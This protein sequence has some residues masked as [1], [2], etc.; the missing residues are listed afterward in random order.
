MRNP[1]KRN[2]SRS[3]IQALYSFTPFK[4]TRTEPYTLLLAP[5]GYLD[6][7]PSVIDYRS[8][9]CKDEFT[10]PKPGWDKPVKQPYSLYPKT[11]SE[12]TSENYVYSLK[13]A[14]NEN[15]WRYPPAYMEFNYKVMKN[16]Y[17][18]QLGW[19]VSSSKKSCPMAKTCPDRKGSECKFYRGPQP[20][21]RLYK[22][23]PEIKSRFTDPPYAAGLE[24]FA[25][26]RYKDSPLMSLSFTEDGEFKALI[27]SVT[28]SPQIP[29]MF[30][31]PSV[32]TQEGIGL[33][34]KN[35]N[36]IELKFKKDVLKDFILDCLEEDKV[37]ANWI[38]VKYYLYQ[39]PD[40]NE[41][42]EIREKRGIPAFNFIEEVVSDEIS[43]TAQ[44]D[45]S[46]FYS[47]VKETDFSKEEAALDFANFVFLHSLA[48]ILRDRLVAE[49]G[50]SEENINYYIDH[51]RLHSIGSWSGKTRIVIFETAIGGFGYLKDLKR[52]IEE[53]GERILYN[54]LEKFIN[55][56]K[57]HKEKTS[58]KYSYLPDNL[59]KFK[60]RYG[61]LVNIV[62]RSYKS[63]FPKI[64]LYPHPNSI[65][66][67]LIDRIGS[68]DDEA[69]GILDDIFQVAPTCWDGCQVC[70]IDET[71]CN[72]LPYDQPY[73]VSSRLLSKG[74]QE[75]LS[76]INSPVISKDLQEGAKEE[77]LS[78]I[79][80]ASNTIDLITP[81]IS[82][83]I[84][85][86][87][88]D[89]YNQ[90]NIRIRI[91]T[92]EDLENDTQIKSIEKLSEICD[93]LPGFECKLVDELHAKGMVVDGIFVLKG[94][95]NFTRSGL[96]S[97]IENIV[98]DFSVEGAKK[99]QER[100][101]K[102]WNRDQT[103]PISEV[104]S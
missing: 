9:A 48:H 97:N 8:R 16:A 102:L 73:L 61:R 47:N 67:A 12:E 37:L 50:C 21:S 20:F 75:I 43:E 45:R 64:S 30:R 65:R 3:G 38:R 36:A 42:P 85:E 31:T 29:Y 96:N 56:I 74:T 66:R 58:K 14:E 87:L 24:P 39:R 27:D 1:N 18:C 10:V 15:K 17:F 46:S 22:V 104:S 83:E 49:Y 63:I 68:L 100:F 99:F 54:L 95:F 33:R 11:F 7:T 60:D 82:P 34:T 76:A 93:I 2:I 44:K 59:E 57:K 84:I 98:Q 40:V 69:H 101:E 6:E 78:S 77:Y 23:Y 94:S 72:F 90:K 88:V 25:S 80:F 19:V 5:V 51:P 35:V 4:L 79:D 71:N 41:D 28:F 52:D 26:I 55:R 53:K 62:K 32:F 91:I 81:W 13:E 92:K 89:I 70:V 103:K 86:D